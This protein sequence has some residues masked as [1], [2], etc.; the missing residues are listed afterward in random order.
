MAEVDIKARVESDI[1]P[2]AGYKT[3]E[4]WITVGVGCAGV[5]L[6]ATGRQDLGAFLLASAGIGYPTSRGLAKL[7]PIGLLK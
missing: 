3:T 1:C 7:N 2:K 4:F 6:L 5:I